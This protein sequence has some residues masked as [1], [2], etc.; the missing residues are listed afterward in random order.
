[1]LNVFIFLRLVTGYTFF[2]VKKCS[3]C[4]RRGSR[5]RISKRFGLM[6]KSVADVINIM[7]PISL[8]VVVLS[9]NENTRRWTLPIKNVILV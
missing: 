1:M 9:K 4:T 7:Q 3:Y 5:I 8:A 2:V 6:F